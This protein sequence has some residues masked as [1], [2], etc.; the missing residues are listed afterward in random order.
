LVS[1]PPLPEEGQLQAD[2]A[3]SNSEAPEADEGQD[4][5][6]VIDSQEDSGSTSS[7][8]PAISK[9]KNLEKKRKRI[10]DLIS[11]STSNPK[12]ASGEPAAAKA[13][14]FEIFDALDS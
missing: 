12:D 4:G 9:D 10:D 11:S 3:P 14:D 6:D 8:P 2:P 13:S 5:N 1:R 7:P